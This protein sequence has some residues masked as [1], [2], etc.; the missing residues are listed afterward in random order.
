[1]GKSTGHFGRVD[2]E[3]QLKHGCDSSQTDILQFAGGFVITVPENDESLRCGEWRASDRRD[4]CRRLAISSGASDDEQTVPGRKD[5]GRL[6][7]G[8]KRK[9]AK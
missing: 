3:R 7:S 1:M 8:V 9:S 6:A 2:Y 4:S 5:L